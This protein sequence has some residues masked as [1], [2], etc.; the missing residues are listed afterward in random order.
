MNKLE[1]SN[2]KNVEKEEYERFLRNQRR[3]R[4][5]KANKVKRF[6]AHILFLFFPG[7]FFENNRGKQIAK[8][9]IIYGLQTLG[10]ILQITSIVPVVLL[11]KTSPFSLSSCVFNLV[12]TL[13]LLLGGLFVRITGIEYKEQEN[14]NKLLTLALILSVIALFLFIF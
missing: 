13:L 2:Q 12:L 11:F 8:N 14:N 6:F 1:N 9:L 10:I 3:Y 7:T 4:K 5:Q